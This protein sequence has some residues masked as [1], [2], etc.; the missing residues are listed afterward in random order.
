MGGNANPT[1]RDLERMGFYE[2]GDGCWVKRKKLKQDKSEEELFSRKPKSFKDQKPLVSNNF[3]LNIDPCPKPR[4]TQKDKWNP[5]EAAQRYFN[6]KDDLNRIAHEIGMPL[7]LPGEIQSIIFMV[8]MPKSWSKKKKNAMYG[9]LNHQVPDI[10]NY[11]KAFMDALCPEDSH[12]AL[13]KGPLGKY[14]NDQG[15]IILKL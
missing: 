7:E 6:W 1:A 14:W 2:D 15:R 5:S 12:I 11:L 8:P 4:M 10:D 13:I 3:M 9:K